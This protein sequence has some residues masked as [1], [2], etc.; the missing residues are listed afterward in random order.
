M[1][2]FNLKPALRALLIPICLAAPCLGK[3]TPVAQDTA[4]LAVFKDKSYVVELVS[5]NDAAK[6]RITFKLTSGVPARPR[7][8]AKDSGKGSAS[9][10]LYEL[11]SKGSK[12]TLNQ[13]EAYDLVFSPNLGDNGSKYQMKI[14]D[15][16]GNFV[17][18]WARKEA[19]TLVSKL[20][21]RIL[22]LSPNWGDGEYMFLLGNSN[23]FGQAQEE[24]YNK[25][26]MKE[27]EALLGTGGTVLSLSTANF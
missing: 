27:V 3:D 10:G 2:N 22:R 9:V 26:K 7:A 19:S 8:G 4:K 1:S 24:A 14:T 18:F 6:D 16:T 23:Y 25:Q 17:K 13:G 20:E 15:S 5:G 21:N 12:V 11:T